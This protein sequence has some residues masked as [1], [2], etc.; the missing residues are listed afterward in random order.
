MKQN[1]NDRHFDND[2]SAYSG[3]TSRTITGICHS[4]SGRASDSGVSISFKGRH[5][6]NFRSKRQIQHAIPDQKGKLVFSFP[7]YVT[8]EIEPVPQITSM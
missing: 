1:C 7:G 6:D 5:R 8:R 2:G 4:G 3:G